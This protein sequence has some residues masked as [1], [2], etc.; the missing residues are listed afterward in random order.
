MTDRL[1]VLFLTQRFL[2][3]M[4]TGGKIRTG[5]LLEQLRGRWDLTLVGNYEPDRDETW[6]GLMEM[7]CERYVKVPW[8]E[9]RR[10]TRGWYWDI[11]KKSFS[12]IPV[13]VQN[14]TSPELAQVV[15]REL[16]SPQYDLFVCDFLQ[17]TANVP[18]PCPHPSLL[19]T[20]N[21]E[22]RIARRHA[23]QTRNRLMKFFWSR[24]ASLMKAYERRVAAHY[25]RVVAVSDSDREEFETGFELQN[26]RTIPTGVDTALF[27]PRGVEREAGPI[28]FCGSMDWLPNQDGVRW[29]VKD[30]LPRVTKEIPEARLVV[31]GRQPPD[32]FVKEVS[33][34]RPVEFTGW[35]E[36]TRPYVDRAACYIVPL[37]IGG[38]TRIKIYEALS[39]Q[40][41]LVS[42]TV[43]AEGLPLEDGEHLHR[44]DEAEG[45]AAKVVQCLRDEEHSRA[46]GKR[47]RDYVKQN[48]GWDKVAD[49]FD[50]IA[51]EA[52][53]A[54][55]SSP[56]AAPA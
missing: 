54:R 28:V 2:F 29:F 48:F 16:C 24:Q 37:R 39:M 17:S 5:K 8:T 21:V 44:E 25:D 35:V 33:R 36:D 38:G 22:S 53:E 26:V 30:V 56:S 52:V 11:F 12:G 9:T 42:T 3:P 31:V 43:G 10:G 13:T 14:D 15:R 20:H 41:A 51:R 4:D 23:E 40:K 55:K 27:E 18:Y 49:A 32:G 7:L 46:M 47:A 50:T 1:K 6:V 34:D 45:F 19:F